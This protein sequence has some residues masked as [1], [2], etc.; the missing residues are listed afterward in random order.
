MVNHNQPTRP[1]RGE[2]SGNNGGDEEVTGECLR[3]RDQCL[4]LVN[5]EGE[6]FKI[7][8]QVVKEGGGEWWKGTRKE[9]LWYQS[10]LSARHRQS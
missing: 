2:N 9:V 10:R 3:V 5:G 8:R 7:S 6:D 1:D 4:K